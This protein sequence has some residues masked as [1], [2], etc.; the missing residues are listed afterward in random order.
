MRRCFFRSPAVVQ[1]YLHSEHVKGFSPL[2][3]SLCVFRETAQVVKKLHW[4]QLCF[5]FKS[6]RSL[7]LRSF[8]ISTDQFSIFWWCPDIITA[9]FYN[10][11]HNL[12]GYVGKFK[13]K[14]KWKLLA[15]L[16]QTINKLLRRNLWSSTPTRLSCHTLQNRLF[17]KENYYRKRSITKPSPLHIPCRSNWILSLCLNHIMYIY[18][19]SFPHCHH[20]IWTSF[21]PIWNGNDFSVCFFVVG[22]FLHRI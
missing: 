9:R 3:I 21:L 7:M 10:N 4:L 2:W 20:F 22:T 14:W 13:K 6:A 16:L 8:V 12:H 17:L 1:E 11:W 15:K 18:Q 5:F 19:F